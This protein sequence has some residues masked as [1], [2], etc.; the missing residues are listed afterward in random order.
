[1]NQVLHFSHSRGLGAILAASLLTACSS[2]P[3]VSQADAAIKQVPQ[4]NFLLAMMGPKAQDPDTHLV[5]DMKCHKSGDQQYDCEVLMV[6]TKWGDQPT[7]AV[8]F[9]KLSGEWRAVLRNE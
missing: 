2:P 1:M 8:R 5:S 7:V 6:K 4:V 3:S 9:I